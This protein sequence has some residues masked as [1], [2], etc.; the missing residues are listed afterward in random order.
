MGTVRSPKQGSTLICVAMLGSLEQSELS[1]SQY[2]VNGV[3]SQNAID[4]GSNV[5]FIYVNASDDTNKQSFYQQYGCSHASAC[6]QSSL[7]TSQTISTRTSSCSPTRTSSCMP[8]TPTEEADEHVDE[9]EHNAHKTDIIQAP[10]AQHNIQYDMTERFALPDLA[11]G[12]TN[13]EDGETDTHSNEYSTDVVTGKGE[14]STDAGG[15]FDFGLLEQ[16][17]TAHAGGVPHNNEDAGASTETVST[18][19]GAVAPTEG[20]TEVTESDL[21]IQNFHGSGAGCDPAMMLQAETIQEPD[22]CNEASAKSDNTDLLTQWYSISDD[23]LCITADEMTAKLLALYEPK[24]KARRART[25]KVKDSATSG[26]ALA[27]NIGEN[28]NTIEDNN[29]E[30]RGPGEDRAEECNNSQ[31]EI[32]K[33][34]QEIDLDWYDSIALPGEEL[35]CNV[36]DEDQQNN[37]DTPGSGEDWHNKLAEEE[38][39]GWSWQNDCERPCGT[40]WCS[41][42]DTWYQSNWQR[43]VARADAST[44]RRSHA[45]GAT[46]A[47]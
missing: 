3:L 44:S 11:I 27:D 43:R 15:F 26:E 40:E 4:G 8:C 20:S 30:A 37:N 1:K 12:G 17:A 24:R 34:N 19:S 29:A 9:T 31:E 18:D 42:V 23:K 5:P 22:C 25:W 32:Y 2:G 13:T 41:S 14:F 33:E 6:S 46:E 7:H 39:V 45:A 21:Y 16:V 38:H 10:Y 35:Q 47:I 36:L 28:N